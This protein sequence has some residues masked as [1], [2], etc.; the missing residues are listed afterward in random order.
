[1]NTQKNSSQSDIKAKK[2]Q[3]DKARLLLQKRLDIISKIHQRV[4]D[5]TTKEN[6]NKD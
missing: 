5:D 4:K 6:N 2:E 1:M 3:F